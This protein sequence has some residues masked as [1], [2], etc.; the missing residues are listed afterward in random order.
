MPGSAR[1]RG[2]DATSVTDRCGKC[3]ARRDVGSAA[4]DADGGTT[5]ALAGD[6][7]VSLRP[8]GAA[9]DSGAALDVSVAGAGLRREVT[10]AGDV[11][12]V[13]RLAAG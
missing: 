11:D 5:L 12:V 13:A 6:V 8:L 10:A 9:R 2:L 7:Y 1:A 4:F 3:F